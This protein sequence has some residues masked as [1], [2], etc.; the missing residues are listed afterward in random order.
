[1]VGDRP[2][3]PGKPGWGSVDRKWQEGI[4]LKQ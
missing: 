3:G 2:G 1:M 4:Q